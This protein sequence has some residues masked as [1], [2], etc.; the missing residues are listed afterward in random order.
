MTIIELTERT[1]D[2]IEKL[3]A[4]WESSV[5]ATHLFLPPGAIE[6]IKAFVPQAL[7]VVPKLIIA[8]DDGGSPLGF[9]GIDDKKVEMLFVADEYRSRGIGSAL[10][11]YGIE[12]YGVNDL[13]VN[14]ENPLARGFYE[15]L[16]FIVYKRT[17]FD[18]QGNAYPLLYMKRS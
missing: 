8:K 3:L 18:E 2:V 10:L 14:E 9:L 17:E 6:A 13:A 1:P 12:Q 15:H 11:G 5:R 4:V 7:A 16:G